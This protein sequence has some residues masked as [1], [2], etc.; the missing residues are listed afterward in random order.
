VTAEALQTNE[1]KDDHD[2][3]DWGPE[4]YA[5]AR[6]AMLKRRSEYIPGVGTC[7]RVRDTAVQL[8]M[9]AIACGDSAC[10]ALF[11]CP[12][13]AVELYDDTEV[14]ESIFRSFGEVSRN[15]F[16]ALCTK[17]YAHRK[18]KMTEL[19][20]P[21]ETLEKIW[22]AKARRAQHLFQTYE[23]TFE[24]MPSGWEHWAIS[25][26]ALLLEKSR[27]F[28]MRDRLVTNLTPEELGPDG[29]HVRQY[30]ENGQ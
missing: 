11:R 30:D 1:T 13:K 12:S 16:E 4:G 25:N 24:C 7:A 17:A 21:Q 8:C 20:L 3:E 6:A 15:Q 23:R 26:A 22:G 29:F 14:R 19:V 18:H 27:R 10:L 5:A 2:D 9:L 28:T